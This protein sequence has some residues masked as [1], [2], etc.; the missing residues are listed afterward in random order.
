MPQISVNRSIRNGSLSQSSR[1]SQNEEN[2][3]DKDSIKLCLAMPGGITQSAQPAAIT[4]NNRL[5]STAASAAIGSTKNDSQVQQVR[6][7]GEI[8]QSPSNAMNSF[9]RISFRQSSELKLNNK[10]QMLGFQGGWKDRKFVEHRRIDL[11]PDEV[12]STQGSTHKLMNSSF[13]SA[14]EAQTAKKSTRIVT[15]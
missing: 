13:T 7:S 15:S 5:I 8:K 14:N 2:Q 3:R 12:H 4:R 11:V 10:N 1:L 9:S 6:E